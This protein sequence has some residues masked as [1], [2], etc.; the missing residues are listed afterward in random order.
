MATGP[1]D[2]VDPK[3]TIFAL[4]NGMDLLKDD[5][6]ERQL[7]WYRDGRER[8]ILITPG[9]AGSLTLTATAWMTNKPETRTTKVVRESVDP[10]A[11]SAALS[12]TLDEVLNAANE[13]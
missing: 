1:F 11:L 7:T 4:A 8:G 9:A 5:A 10:A 3:L 6:G 12:Q 2:M 13:L